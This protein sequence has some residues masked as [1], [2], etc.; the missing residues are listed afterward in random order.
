MHSSS[1]I[2][3]GGNRSPCCR[4][5]PGPLLVKVCLPQG[6]AEPPPEGETPYGDGRV[7]LLL[8]RDRTG[9]ENTCWFGEL[10][11]RPRAGAVMSSESGTGIACPS[12]VN[13][14]SR[15]A[16]RCRFSGDT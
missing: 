9:V 10:V 14:R 5:V 2:C 6:Q 8:R 12:R 7:S 16:A 13:D 11:G 3:M 4:W 1:R 15:E